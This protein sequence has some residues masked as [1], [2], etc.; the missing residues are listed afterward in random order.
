MKV[1][2]AKVGEVILNKVNNQ[3]YIVTEV[4]EPIDDITVATAQI[5]NPDLKEISQDVPEQVEITSA[6]A[7]IYKHLFNTIKENAVNDANITEGKFYLND[8]DV[9]TGEIVPVKVLGVT[10]NFVVFEGRRDN[11]SFA[12]IYNAKRDHFKT[13][14]K[15]ENIEVLKVKNI[16]LLT[17]KRAEDVLDKDTGEV[18]GQKYYARVSLV[19]ENEAYEE[20]Y[21]HFRAQK[22]ALDDKDSEVTTEIRRDGKYAIISAKT[23]GGNVLF[24]CE[25][26]HWIY[27]SYPRDYIP[28]NVC[29]WQDKLSFITPDYF[30]YDVMGEER[31]IRID[32]T[33]LKN[34]KELFEVSKSGDTTEY[35]F[36]DD[37]MKQV[38]TITVTSTNDRGDVVT[39]SKA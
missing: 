2:R 11:D 25:D 7:R 37:E 18:T 17:D 16:I 8:V 35:S 21:Y 15:A 13:L 34:Y 38:V 33:L 3:R 39:I 36:T 12:Y 6:N 32:T 5:Y 23:E 30:I 19:V 10:D 29:K 24:I 28:T 26:N 31:I 1:E 22:I 4:A 27:T 20:G 14:F 9:P